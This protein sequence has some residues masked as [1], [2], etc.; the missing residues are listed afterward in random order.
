[1]S[2]CY[3]LV[4]GIS[5]VIDEMNN[6]ET[7]RP[8][9]VAVAHTFYLFIYFFKLYDHNIVKHGDKADHYAQRQSTR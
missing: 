1:M 6:F 5:S 8:F 4:A 2:A 9:G 3:K 7:V